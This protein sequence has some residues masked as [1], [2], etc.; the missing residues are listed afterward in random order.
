MGDSVSPA[1]LGNGPAA[2]CRGG[3]DLKG[4]DDGAV[5]AA[6]AAACCFP[7]SPFAGEESTVR[8]E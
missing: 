8:V 3:G 4:E 2:W 6:T 5:A 1:T 7:G